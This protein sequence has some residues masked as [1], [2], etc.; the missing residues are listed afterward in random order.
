MKALT[1]SSFS[2]FEFEK[3]DGFHLIGF[4]LFIYNDQDFPSQKW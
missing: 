3:R 1:D 2:F 4:A